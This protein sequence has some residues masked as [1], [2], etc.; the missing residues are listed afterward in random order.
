MFDNSSL[1]KKLKK[2]F[3][4]GHQRD[5]LIKKNI[6]FSYVFKGLDISLGFLLIPLVLSY[7]NEEQYGVW[8]LLFSLTGYFSFMDV[9]LSHGLRN[10]FAEAKAKNE[11][12]KLRYYVSTTYALLAIISSIFFVIFLMVNSFVNWERILNTKIVLNDDLSVLALFVFG[13]FSLQFVFKIII[14]ILT[15]D[16]RP[17]IINLQGFLIKCLQVS[18]IIILIKF[19]EGSLVLLGAAFSMIPI[20]SLLGL[21]IYYFSK[22]YAHIRPKIAYVNFSYL[23]DLM[24]VGIKFFFITLAGIILFSTDNLII[25]QLYGPEQVTPYQIA[26]KYFGISLMLFAIIVQPL[27]SA[28]T[29]AYHKDDLIWIKSAMK[30]M[31]KIWILFSIG[32]LLLLIISPYFFKLWLGD[33]V[34]ISFILSVSWFVFVVIQSYNMIYTYFINGVGKLRVQLY[35]T[36]FSIIF[37]IPASIFLAKTLNMGVSGVIMATTISMLLSAVIKTIQYNKIINLRAHGVWNK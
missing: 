6:L 37:N 33:K 7:L 11:I 32:S 12:E 35:I 18:I 29:D 27:W 25:T 10:K 31:K 24:N 17:S 15:A 13:A 36:V 30:K 5:Q 26:N 2:R 20:V 28:V 14:T 19:T 34:D 16:Q 4:Q 21:T 23:N 3:F 22:D 1:I 8:I 9:G